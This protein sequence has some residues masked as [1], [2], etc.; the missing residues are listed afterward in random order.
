MKPRY[1]QENSHRDRWMVSYVDVLTILL[2]FFV[3]AAARTMAPPPPA[4]KP[5][6]KPPLSEIEQA[7]KKTNLEVRREP[8]G[9][10]ISLPQAILFS[11]GDD[12]VS[13]SALPTVEKIV[14]AIRDLP[15]PVVLVG[16]ADSTPIHNRHFRDNWELSAARG[17]RLLELLTE[18]YGIDESRLSVSSQGSN[19]PREPNDT[20]D[21]RASNRRVEIVILADFS[22]TPIADSIR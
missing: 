8:R 10:V 11:S 17:V 3:A 5:K 16:H 4:E 6:P 22:G 9:L 15:N 21:G 1:L 13:E 14:G 7:L 12:C 20:P 2:I 18:R 19:H